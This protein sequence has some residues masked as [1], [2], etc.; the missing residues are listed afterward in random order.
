MGNTWKDMALLV[1]EEE[2]YTGRRSV[3]DISSVDTFLGTTDMLILA[4]TVI[5]DVMVDQWRGQR[6]L[7]SG[8]A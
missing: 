7:W 3:A 4:V 6:R 1:H 8:L 2:I 5:L